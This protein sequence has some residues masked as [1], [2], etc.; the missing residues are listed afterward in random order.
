VD[1]YKTTSLKTY[2]GIS[3]VYWSKNQILG[4]SL[5]NNQILSLVKN[6]ILS[7][8]KHQILDLSLVKS[9]KFSIFLSSPFQAMDDHTINQVLPPQQEQQQQQQQQQLSLQEQ[10]RLLTEQNEAL[11][12]TQQVMNNGLIYSPEQKLL[13]RNTSFNADINTIFTSIK[14]LK[15]SLNDKESIGHV[16]DID[17]KA[18]SKPISNV[19]AKKK[20]KI[21]TLYNEGIKALYSSCDKLQEFKEKMNDVALR[22]SHCHQYRFALKRQRA[23]SENDGTQRQARSSRM[24][25][26]EATETDLFD[27]ELDLR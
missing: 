26:D 6:Q 8:V 20:R 27:D 23:I 10:I 21:D 13:D 17:F 14:K 12:Q 5:V 24:I 9:Q 19:Y 22:N 16:D 2:L 3:L 18:P 4:L 11:Q 7:L 1:K 25:D 15:E